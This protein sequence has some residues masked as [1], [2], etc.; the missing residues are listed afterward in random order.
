MDET[1]G[2]L[3][4]A[5]RDATT[6]DPGD[7]D[8]VDVGPQSLAGPPAHQTRRWVRPRPNAFAQ[9]NVLAQEGAGP[10][11]CA[12]HCDFDQPRLQIR[13]REGNDHVPVCLRVRTK[14][15]STGGSQSRRGEERDHP[16]NRCYGTTHSRS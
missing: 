5:V 11:G 1:F 2:L 7:L 4:Q 9:P 14:N 12:R 13:I 6:F 8:V 15:R 3:W 10:I 16:N